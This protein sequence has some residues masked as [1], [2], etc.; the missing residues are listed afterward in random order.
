M[1]QPNPWILFMGGFALLNVAAMVYGTKAWPLWV[2]YPGGVIFVLMGVMSIVLG[3]AR[4]FKKKPAPPT[5]P[6]RPGSSAQA[7]SK[8]ARPSSGTSG[9]A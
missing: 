9:S 2:R 3:F 6:I 7:P 4:Q 1:N 8:K 5:K